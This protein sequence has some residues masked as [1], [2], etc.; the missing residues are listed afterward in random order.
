[1]RTMSCRIWICQVKKKLLEF[2]LAGWA[3]STSVKEED[4][5]LLACNSLPRLFF[6]IQDHGVEFLASK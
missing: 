3:E 5:A 2:D 6:N 1:M 4:N